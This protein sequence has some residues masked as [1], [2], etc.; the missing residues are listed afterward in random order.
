MLHPVNHVK[1]LFFTHFQPVGYLL[2]F[3]F[4]LQHLFDILNFEFLLGMNN[5]YRNTGFIGTSR[6][7]AAM[8]VNFNIIRQVVID[9]VCQ[10]AYIQSAGSHIRSHK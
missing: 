4:T 8:C 6:T 5:G 10:I 7:S 9:Y 3:E 2:L 1:K